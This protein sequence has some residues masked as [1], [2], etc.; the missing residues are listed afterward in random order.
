MHTHS[1]MASFKKNVNKKNILKMINLFIK[2]VN[3]NTA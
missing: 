3:K 2:C 1:E